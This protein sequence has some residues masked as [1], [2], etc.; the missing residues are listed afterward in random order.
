MFQIRPQQE[1]RL[2]EGARFAFLGRVEEHVR[3]THPKTVK[4]FEPAQLRQFVERHW[5]EARGYGLVSEQA[6]CEY[7][8]AVCRLGE[9]FATACEWAGEVLKSPGYE[10]KKLSQLREHVQ[11]AMKP[12]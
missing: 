8:D 12:D 1:A 4:G 9:D 11:A 3:A 10:A 7:L 5:E 6:L 2:K